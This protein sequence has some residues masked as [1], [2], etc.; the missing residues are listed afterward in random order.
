MNDQEYSKV[1]L[2]ALLGGE[3]KTKTSHKLEGNTNRESVHFCLLIP[4]FSPLSDVP[5]RV[6]VLGPILKRSPIKTSS[7]TLSGVKKIFK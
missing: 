2:Y 6:F 4:Y 3:H 1:F 7:L 5:E